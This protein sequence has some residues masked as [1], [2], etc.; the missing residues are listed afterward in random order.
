MII[1]GIDGLMG[2]RKAIERLLD[3][4]VDVLVALAQN[5]AM[6]Y[7]TKGFSP[8]TGV[9][10]INLRGKEGQQIG[11]LADEYVALS[12]FVVALNILKRTT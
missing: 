8:Q 11:H 4:T 9:Q 2:W 7:Q 3:H 12:G 5:S 10:F 6:T 1:M